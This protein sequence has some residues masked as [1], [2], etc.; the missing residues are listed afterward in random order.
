MQVKSVVGF[1]DPVPIRQTGSD[2]KPEL[3]PRL[4]SHNVAKA[5]MIWVSASKEGVSFRAW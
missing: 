4:A 3:V 1:H 2:D 5:R